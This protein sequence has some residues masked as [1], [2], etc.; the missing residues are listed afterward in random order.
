MPGWTAQAR[1]NFKTCANEYADRYSCNEE[2][3]IAHHYFDLHDPDNIF[4][5]QTNPHA[6]V[7]NIILKLAPSHHRL[8]R[9]NIAYHKTY[10]INT[11]IQTNASAVTASAHTCKDWRCPLCTC[12]LTATTKQIPEG[13]TIHLHSTT[14]SHKDLSQARYDL[15]KSISEHI[16]TI[17]DIYLKSVTHWQKRTYIPASIPG[18][19][20]AESRSNTCLLKDLL[21]NWII[22]STLSVHQKSTRTTLLLL[23]YNPIRIRL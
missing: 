22:I 15:N 21:L 12:Q 8:L 23:Q 4:L 13:D 19:P 17:T 20:S 2:G 9:T 18:L 1:L 14:C 16:Q 6:A 10:A 7:R 5:L 3:W 11:T